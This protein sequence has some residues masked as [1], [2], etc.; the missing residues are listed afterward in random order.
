MSLR[1]ILRALDTVISLVPQSLLGGPKNLKGYPLSPLLRVILKAQARNKVGMGDLEPEQLRLEM[2]SRLLPLR[3]GYEV[4]Q[5]HNLSIDLEGRSLKARHYIPSG[6]EPP[7]GLTVY[8]HGGGYI[9]GDLDTHDDVCRLLCREANTQIISVDYRLAPEHPFPAGVMD[10][11]EAFRWVQKNAHDF[12][13]KPSEVAVGGDSAGGNLA[14]VSVQATQSNDAP[15]AQLLLYPGTD[16]VTKRPSHLA[17]GEGFFLDN[18]DR[19]VF[20][21]HYL[22]GIRGDSH[23]P[24]VSPYLGE[25]SEHIAPALIATAGFDALHDEGEA[26]ANKLARAGGYVDYVCF[27][28]LGHGF[29]NLVGI[30][31]ASEK[32]LIEVGQRWRRLFEQRAA[33]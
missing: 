14:A 4:G 20:R 33:G 2:R 19:A 1:T 30:H 8:F 22:K 25:V 16:Q 18:S 32:A 13:V 23:D 12:G 10:A 11:I 21:Q 31:R 24:Q 15:I 5:V 17:F 26:Y 9:F 7:Q 6:K 29:G 28:Q 3:A 27:E